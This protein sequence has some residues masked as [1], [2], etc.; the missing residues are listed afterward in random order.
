M[1]EINNLDL[2][3]FAKFLADYLLKNAPDLTQTQEQPHSIERL[4]EEQA[5]LYHNQDK[6]ATTL[7]RK[8]INI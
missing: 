2:D 4:K 5:I 3:V 8:G 6:S 1:V 7:N